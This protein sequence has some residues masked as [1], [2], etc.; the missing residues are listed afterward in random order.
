MIVKIQ[1]SPKFQKRFRVTMDNGKTYD[2]GLKN[3]STYLDHHNKTLRENYWKRHLANPT[4]KK[5]FEGLVPS[6][7]LF[8][9]ALLWGNSTNLDENIQILNNLW[10]KYK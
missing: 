4:E 6:P 10:K 2:F 3:G 5:L 8:S 7:S 9:L 1:K